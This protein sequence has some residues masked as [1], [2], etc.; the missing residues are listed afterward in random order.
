MLRLFV[1]ALSIILSVGM[2]VGLYANSLKESITSDAQTQSLTVP[3][4]II[5]HLPFIIN[6]T[7]I[8]YITKD[9]NVNGDGITILA[10]N[11]VLI[12]QGNT[13]TG[14]GIGTG[15][16][17]TANM[18]TVTDCNINNFTHGINVEQTRNANLIKNNKVSNNYMGIQ[19]NYMDN[20]TPSSNNYVRENLIINN[21]MGIRIFKSEKNYIYDNYFADNQYNAVDDS[22]YRSYWNTTKTTESNIIGGPFMGGNYWTDYTGMDT[23][24]DGL[25]NTDLPYASSGNI[26]IGGDYLPLI[27][28]IPP[29]YLTTSDSSPVNAV[30][31]VTWIDNVQVN[32][33][34]LEVDGVNYTDLVK[35]HDRLDFSEYYGVQCLPIQHKVVYAKSFT[36]LTLG[37]HYYRWFANDT[38]N[39]WNST[40]LLSFNVTAP[41]RVNT[42][43]M[44]PILEATAN[45]T[46]EGVSNIT[47]A[48]NYVT[49]HF[50][51]DN[52]WFAMNMN[53]NPETSL[54]SLLIPEYNE[55]A[56]KTIYYYVEA[57][58]KYGN[59]VTSDTITYQVPEWVVGDLNRDAVIDSTDLGIMGAYWGAMG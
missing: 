36:N 12:G 39:Y 6:A 5:D 20:P 46:C 4:N 43:E 33:S 28:T 23:D 25:G 48:M 2:F 44:S 54:Y 52:T 1:L 18:V 42:V 37:T 56:N 22:G 24:G 55:L 16:N 50:K 41:P 17:I 57:I 3:S 11:T 51:M 29:N 8:Y 13:I 14:N 40:E 15:I 21:N 58:D 38:S 7:D 53:Y 34:I 9:L 49:L 30:L 27:D 35:V 32:T 31:N 59:T 26:W 19:F 45:I 10:N 47:E